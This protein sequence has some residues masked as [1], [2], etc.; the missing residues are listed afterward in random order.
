M[1]NRTVLAALLGLSL[2]GNAVLLG[3]LLNRRD[4]PA[5]A[6]QSATVAAPAGATAQPTGPV[7]S[8]TMRPTRRPPVATTPTTEPTPDPSPTATAAAPMPD[9]PTP[10]APT[11]VAT[12]STPT[13]APLPSPTIVA[14]D[15]DWLRYLNGFRVAAGLP[16]LREDSA[17]SAES[18]LHSRYMILS[19]DV[20][21][22]EDPNNPFY[23]NAGN[24]AGD[25]GNIAI[26]NLS[27]APFQWAIN[28]W[29]SAP[30]HAV[31]MLDPQLAVTG[32]G[33]YRDPGGIQAV[34]ATLDVERGLGA[35]PDGVEFPVMW[36][37]NDSVT[38]VLRYSLPEFPAALS[39][40]TGYSQA[41]GAPI[42]L[43]LGDGR[44]TPNVTAT[45]LLRD[46]EPLAHC[47][48]DETNYTHSDAWTQRSARTILDQRDAVVL[49]PAAPLVPDATYAVRV[50]ANGQTYTWSFRT[51]A[52]PPQER[53]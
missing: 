20:G 25:T 52:G 13:A 30:F 31:P 17:W 22:S 47:Q 8:P 37:G 41:T 38:W 21:H 44:L 34:G 14:F 29:L 15:P 4:V 43:Q 36:P 48:F 19:G 50:D 2:L 23:T 5:V 6:G 18:G 39:H 10:V 16:A 40:C 32:F 3:L 49:I 42:I 33:E 45:T 11:N 35:L 24:A 12:T 53:D 7:A 26:G 46:G 27:S 28:Y 9:T 1:I 51:A